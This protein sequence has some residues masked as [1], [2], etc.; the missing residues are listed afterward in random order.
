MASYPQSFDLPQA[1]NAPRNPQTPS[2]QKMTGSIRD[3]SKTVLS[4]LGDPF[5]PGSG[6][7]CIPCESKSGPETI[8]SQTTGSLVGA[9]AFN[10]TAGHA[11]SGLSKTN[12]DAFNALDGDLVTNA[13]KTSGSPASYVNADVTSTAGTAASNQQPEIKDAGGPDSKCCDA[14]SHIGSWA[15][16][17]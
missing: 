9:A 14:F 11:Q 5:L 1:S 10:N 12:I 16:D 8:G 7:E 15:K 3:P 13:H 4:A 17:Q 2:T 6:W